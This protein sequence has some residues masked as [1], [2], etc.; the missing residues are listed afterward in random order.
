MDERLV[1]SR[2]DCLHGIVP[3]ECPIIG[4]GDMQACVYIKKVSVSVDDCF[5]EDNVD[6]CPYVRSYF[7]SSVEGE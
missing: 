7:H 6:K 2:F 3:Q 5:M 1:W 4:N